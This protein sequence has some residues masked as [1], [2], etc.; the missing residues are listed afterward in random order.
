M[1][2]GGTGSPYDPVAGNGTGSKP[3]SGVTNDELRTEES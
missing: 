3:I 1:L 2:M